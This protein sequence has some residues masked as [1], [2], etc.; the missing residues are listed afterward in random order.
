MGSIHVGVAGVAKKASKD[1]PFAVANEI[2]C[3]DLARALLLPIP[4]GFII[5][6]Q[7]GGLPVPYHVSLNF[8]LAGEDLPPIQ[9]SD[10]LK[11]QAQLAAG[12]LAFDTWILNNDRHTT[13]IAYYKAAKRLQIFDHSHAFF[14]GTTREDAAKYL[15]QHK[16]TGLSYHCLALA[17][18][19]TDSIKMWC[20]R[21]AQIPEFFIRETIKCTKELGL[22]GQ[23]VDDCVNFLLERRKILYGLLVPKDN[24]PKADEKGGVK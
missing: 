20:D 15:A 14:Y 24:G 13:N 23:D 9:V 21:I 22:P 5:H 10:V 8:N 17:V 3:G 16:T 1:M 18:S 19:D 7:E 6:R 4:P 11:E 12:V 2:I